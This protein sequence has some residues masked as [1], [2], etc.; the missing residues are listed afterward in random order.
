MNLVDKCDILS[1]AWD[2]FGEDEVWTGFFDHADLGIPFAFGVSNGYILD[3]SPE[4]EA[5]IQDTWEFF[6]TIL[7][8]SSVQEWEGLEEM[9]IAAGILQEA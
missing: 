5:L 1:D 8:L 6:C 3:M 7:N 9:M 2:V 4:G